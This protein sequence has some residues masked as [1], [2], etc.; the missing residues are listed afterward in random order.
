MGVE[1]PTKRYPGEPRP[2]SVPW[3]VPWRERKMQWLYHV[4][5]D[6]KSEPMV[7]TQ[8]KARGEL[9]VEQRTS[10]KPEPQPNVLKTASLMLPSR[11]RVNISRFERISS[12]IINFDLQ[13]HDIATSRSTNDTSTNIVIVL[14]ER[15][16]VSR[17]LGVILGVRGSFGGSCCLQWPCRDR[18]VQLALWY[19]A[20]QHCWLTELT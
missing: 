4:N 6:F 1:E 15:T 12:T 11:K 13:F 2:W 16:D 17:V 10:H 7:I 14:I 20:Q 18:N 9:R 19:E 5:I 8:R 3:S